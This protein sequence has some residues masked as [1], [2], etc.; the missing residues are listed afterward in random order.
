M[1]RLDDPDAGI[2]PHRSFNFQADHETLV[3]GVVTD[4]MKNFFTAYRLILTTVLL[5]AALLTF[6]F[7][8]QDKFVEPEMLGCAVVYPSN[9]VIFSTYYNNP[10][11]H[12]GRAVFEANCKV[13]HRLDQKLL[14]PALRGSFQRSDSLWYR[15]MIKNA[16]ALIRSGDALAVLL[17]KEY[18]QIQHPSY[19]K[20]S[21]EMLNDLIE[22]LKLEGERE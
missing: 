20:M 22:Y 7:A 14:G 4:K 21:D 16:P 8:N 3:I 15:K 12:K 9:D 17:Y 5:T 13:C 1:D 18:D 10:L 2:D 6:V 11:D 19:E